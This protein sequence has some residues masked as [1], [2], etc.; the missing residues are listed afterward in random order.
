MMQG[1]IYP[2]TLFLQKEMSRYDVKYFCQDVICQYSKW[3]H[4]ILSQRPNDI[5][6]QQLKNMKPFLSVMHAKAHS[7]S[8]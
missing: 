7:W 2:Y 8:C 1:E 6:L 5:E 4:K 3:L